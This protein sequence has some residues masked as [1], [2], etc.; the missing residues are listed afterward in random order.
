MSL[1][2]YFAE[3]CK[4]AFHNHFITFSEHP[5][6]VEVKG[7]DIVEKVGYCSKYNEVA[8]TNLMEVFKLILRVVV[9][10]SLPQS[11]LPKRLYI[12]SDMEFDSCT[13]DSD[14]TNFEFAKRLYSSMATSCRKLC[15]GMSRAGKRQQPVTQNE[16]GVALVSGCSQHMFKLAVAG[17][18]SPV[19]LMYE[20]LTSER[21]AKIT[22]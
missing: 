3:R 4:G 17:E 11:E 13:R 21:Y 22:A 5:Q 6:L 9:G 7:A 8:N 2:I 10:H 15:S 20:I 1:G 12:I 18:L 19:K 16:A 14:M